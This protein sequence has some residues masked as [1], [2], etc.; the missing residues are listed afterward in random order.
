MTTYS[1]LSEYKHRRRLNFLER[2]KQEIHSKY[3]GCPIH[4]V[5]MTRRVEIGTNY[6]LACTVVGCSEIYLGRDICLGLSEW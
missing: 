6:Y 3:P 5:P 1:N 2:V 4:K